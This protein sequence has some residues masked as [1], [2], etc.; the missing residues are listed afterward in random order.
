MAVYAFKCKCGSMLVLEN[1]VPPVCRRPGCGK[2]MQ[3]D[4]KVANKVSNMT[5][6]RFNG[7]YGVSTN[8]QHK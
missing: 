4:K 3:L 8:E 5:I 7:T 6:A 2:Q 1:K